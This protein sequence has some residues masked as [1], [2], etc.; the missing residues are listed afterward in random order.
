MAMTA[1]ALN[2]YLRSIYFK[3]RLARGYAKYEILS[4]AGLREA[5]AQA[6]RSKLRK[7]GTA[8]QY[9]VTCE[10]YL[11]GP[12]VRPDILIWKGKRPRI[13]IELKDTR[14]F[15]RE[16]AERDWQKLQEVC[17]EYSSVKAG[18]LIYVARTGKKE[19][20]IKRTR[21][22]LRFWA[23]PIILEDWFGCDFEKWHKEY[24]RRI[25]FRQP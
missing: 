5:V 20:V 12:N 3:R 8:K 13:W 22:T 23:I 21:K 7:L 16:L 24:K 1:A 9:L 11:P 18:Y 17:A 19:F 6:I 10:V 14:T 4:E 2:K 15:E 25:L